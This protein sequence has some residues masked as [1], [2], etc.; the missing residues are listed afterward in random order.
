MAQH[1][2]ATLSDLLWHQLVR[3]QMYEEILCTS[4]DFTRQEMYSRSDPQRETWGAILEFDRLMGTDA[5]QTIQWVRERL[6]Q[7]WTI[8][9]GGNAPSPNDDDHSHVRE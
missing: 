2:S 4:Q 3:Q 8:A 5:A 7:Y 9:A 6:E 1:H